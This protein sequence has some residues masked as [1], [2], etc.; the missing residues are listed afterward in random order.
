[1]SFRVT[2]KFRRLLEAAAEQEN[3]SLTNMLETLLLEFCSKRG[4]EEPT[5]G[6]EPKDSV[7][8]PE[9]TSAVSR[10]KAKP[11]S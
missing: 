5:S 3:R 7:L 4:I 1:M 10:P 8:T 2:P 11:R 9:L 6:L